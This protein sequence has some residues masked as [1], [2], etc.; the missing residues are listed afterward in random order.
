M[1]LN[2]HL[3]SILSFFSESLEV[4]FVL[5]QVKAKLDKMIEARNQ[6]LS[7]YESMDV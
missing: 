4:L 2:L 3:D 6:A 7:L 1:N 5:N